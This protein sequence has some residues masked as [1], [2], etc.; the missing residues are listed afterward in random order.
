ML[1]MY[2]ICFLKI[3]LPCTYCCKAS[4]ILSILG[5]C[6]KKTHVGDVLDG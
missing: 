2:L 5:V 6:N 3:Y 4:Y 1:Y